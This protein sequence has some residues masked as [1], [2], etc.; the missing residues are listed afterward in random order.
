MRMLIVAMRDVCTSAK[1]G[2]EMLHNTA[3]K[4]PHDLWRS[5]CSWRNAATVEPPRPVEAHE[6]AEHSSEGGGKF[7]RQI[8]PVAVHCP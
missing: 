3:I 6:K 4:E 1:V 5:I 7:D 8:G 2:G